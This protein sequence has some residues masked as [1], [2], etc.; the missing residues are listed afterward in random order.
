MTNYKLIKDSEIID[1]V[2]FS[3]KVALDGFKQTTK[4]IVAGMVDNGDDTFSIP[5]K[6]QRQVLIEEKENAILAL[7]RTILPNG[8]I[9]YT[10]DKSMIDLMTADR[11]AE[12]LGATDEDFTEWKTVDG[13]KQVKIKDIRDA[14]DLRLDNKANAIGVV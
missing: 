3:S 5:P 14:I 6:D 11:K 4:K 13:I 10:D 7:S 12:R 9:F 8:L 1:Q 2:D